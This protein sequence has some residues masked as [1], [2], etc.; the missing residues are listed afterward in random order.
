MRSD[1][2]GHG[3]AIDRMNE[4]I[5]DALVKLT[6]EG[7]KALLALPGR[8][9]ALVRRVPA[10]VQIELRKLSSRGAH[11][12]R[13]IFAGIL[14]VGLVAIVAGYGRLGRGPISLPTLVPSIEAA[15]NGE[16][17]D[18]HVKIDDA[19]LQRTAD[20]PGVL[21]RLRNIRLIDKDGSILAQAPLAAIGLSGSALLSGRIAPGS[22]DFIGPRLLLFY[23]SDRGLSLSFSKTAA[24]ENETV[25]RGSL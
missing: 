5:S 23:D 4:P 2:L 17:S 8:G 20:G 21:F 24:G 15:I 10:P 14:V 25:I 22:V 9:R 1:G 11:V 12:C 13:E 18:L 6:T 3:G 7:G 16:L 19:I